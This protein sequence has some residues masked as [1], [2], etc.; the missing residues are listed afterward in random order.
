MN[1][2]NNELK[3]YTGTPQ[4]ATL[5]TITLTEDASNINGEHIMHIIKIIEGAGCGEQQTIKS[6]N[7]KTKVATLYGAW[8]IIPD[9]TSVYAI[10]NTGLTKMSKKKM[11]PLSEPMG[12]DPTC[13]IHGEQCKD[14]F[15]SCENDLIKFRC[16]LMIEVDADVEYGGGN[17]DSCF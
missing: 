13:C 1:T 8:T 2:T 3:T 17:P 12:G 14:L 7:G 10:I 11:I 5:H 4:S 9:E 16:P 15:T 6:Y